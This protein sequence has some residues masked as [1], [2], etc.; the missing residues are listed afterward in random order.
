MLVDVWLHS[1]C[2]LKYVVI[3]CQWM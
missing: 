3:V 2:C 1:L